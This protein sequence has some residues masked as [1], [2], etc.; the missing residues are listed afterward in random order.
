MK[1]LETEGVKKLKLDDYEVG[2]TLG[3][4]IIFLLCRWIRESQGG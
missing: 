3:K 2:R 4:G 1:K